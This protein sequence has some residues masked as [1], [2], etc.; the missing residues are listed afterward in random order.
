[1]LALAALLSAPALAFVDPPVLVPAHP[2]GG[3]LVTLQIRSGQCDGFYVDP[4]YPVITRTG[5][6]V[7]I[8]VDAGHSD[9]SIL[10]IFSVYTASWPVGRFEPGRYTVQVDRYVEVNLGDS[11]TETLGTLTLSVG[12]ASPVPLDHGDWLALLAFGL[13]AI[14]SLFCTASPLAS[15]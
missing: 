8:T 12:Q 7:H 11:Y 9:D 1:L 13:A 14:A 6:A 15:R 5:N 3:E 10:C 4:N 2:L